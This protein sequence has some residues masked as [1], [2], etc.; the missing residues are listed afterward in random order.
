MAK[1]TK[2]AP[3]KKA[4]AANKRKQLPEPTR[5]SPRQYKKQKPDEEDAVYDPAAEDDAASDADLSAD[6]QE[7]DADTLRKQ[8]AA[9]QKRVQQL[10]QKLAMSVQIKKHRVK[11]GH[12]GPQDD[13]MSMTW[14][15]YNTKNMTMDQKVICKVFKNEGWRLF[16]FCNKTSLPKVCAVVAECYKSD[17]YAKNGDKDYDA[18]KYW[19]LVHWSCFLKLSL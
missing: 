6:G 10:Q 17:L 2:P 8:L 5:K 11:S 9:E 13:S 15:S 18:R 19:I 16:K 1:T 7:S 4:G 3:K 14:S 12:S